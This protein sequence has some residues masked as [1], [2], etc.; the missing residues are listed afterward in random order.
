MPFISND[1]LLNTLAPT[2]ATPEQVKEAVRINIDARLV[3]LKVSFFTLAGLALLA[4]FPA[5]GLPGYVRGEIP[6][7]NPASREQGRKGP[8]AVGER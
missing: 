7:S 2:S 6:G 4:F 8:V 1:Q 5:A 3:A